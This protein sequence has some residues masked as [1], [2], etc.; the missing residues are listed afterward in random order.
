[1]NVA[2]TDDVPS[3]ISGVSYSASN[4]ATGTGNHIA[5]TTDLAVGTSL[6][7][8]VTGKV[9]SDATGA[10]SNTASAQL[11][12]SSPVTSVAAVTTVTSSS[13]ISI[14]KVG[15]KAVV[16]GDSIHYL[17]TVTNA[18]PSEA[19]NVTITD[20][21]PSSISGVSYSASN[22]V[23]GTGN[24][25]AFTTDLAVGATLQIRVVGKV[26]SE[27][28]G[29]LSNT[30]S[31]QLPGSSPVTSAAAVT[32]VT[33]SS[34]I[35]IT[36]VGD[37]AVVAGDSIHYLIT[38]TNAGPSEARNVAITD[39]VPS[40]ISGVSYSASNGATGA[41]NHIAFTSDLAAGASIQ[42]RVV[43]KVS[44]DATGELSN[45]ASAQLPGERPVTSVAAV[46]TVTSSS[47]ISITKVGDKAV[48][49]G[50]SIH[51]LITVTNAGPSEARNVAITDDV[52]SSISGVSY[53]AS[54]GATGTGNHIAIT[55]DLAVGTS[56]QIRIAGKVSSDATG[57]LSNTASAQLPGTSPVTSAAAVTTVGSSS[58]ISITKVGDKQVVAGDSI[59]YLITVTNAGPS[60]AKN[61][62]ITDDVPSSIS[63]VS[64]SASNGATGI[65]NHI[66]L[67]VNLN[68]NEILTIN[69]SGVVSSTATGP[70]SNIASVKNNEITISSS[71][72]I[73]NIIV[74]QQRVDLAIS[75]NG[76]IASLSGEEIVYTLV[77]K[78]NGPDACENALVIDDVPAGITQIQVSA[79]ISDAKTSV[80][81]NLVR[82]TIGKL[83]VDQE[84]LITIKGI[85][86]IDGAIAN[87]AT[88]KAPDG[89]T[90]INLSNNTSNIV[91]TNV[92]RKIEADIEL[93]KTLKNTGPLS[94]GEKAGFN[95]VVTDLGPF[96]AHQIIVRDT[97]QDNLDVVGGFN[98][99]TGN[100][101]YD[102]ATRIIIWTIDSLAASQSA[103]L[104]Y[105]TR[106]THTGTVMNVAY[107]SAATP[108]PRTAN[109]IAAINPVI[110]TGDDL[111]IPNIITPNGDGKND[112]FVIIGLSHFPGSQLFIYNRWGNLVYQAK[113]YQNDWDGI[114]LN[115]GTY[116]YI[117]KVNTP[118]GE[119][120][121]KG[122][123]ELLR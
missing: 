20:D 8:R 39:D 109:N 17:I 36:K 45:T 42:I 25:I 30:A 71:P 117:L 38:V 120:S 83:N 26:P 115:E 102:A 37:K 78:N 15:D 11:P 74:P 34:Q 3:S 107:V 2:I 116:F 60:E 97:L 82:V 56:I 79:S 9:S 101:S 119:K 90:D 87:S 65:G 104:E 114:N 121:Y 72:A 95:I 33:L 111:Y 54:N 48:V 61:V 86:T 63:G 46:T 27:A 80:D 123:V 110:V 112:K 94:V 89:V 91:R 13:Q 103:T 88:I 108:D 52:P 50:D 59:H 76:P 81:G 40:S 14:T 55:T 41:G 92:S 99:S 29:E 51:Y 24:H 64:Y 73:T 1:R 19:R 69:V 98:V 113:N 16:A 62:T 85:L 70:V 47:Q 68:P 84:V 93:Q 106:I 22:G 53:S 57:E 32:T 44:S 23:T 122:W 18:G 49:A 43:G 75:K 58:Q 77:A 12:G 28:T 7:I 96:T 5:F 21:V 67:L 35:S 66:G 105:T 6:Q 10:L 31:A 4:G 118:T 100:V